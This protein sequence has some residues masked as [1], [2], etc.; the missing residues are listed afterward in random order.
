MIKQTLI[1]FSLLSA[2][3]LSQ[4]QAEY[5]KDSNI[6]L[7]QESEQKRHKKPVFTDIDLDENGSI[8]LEEFKQHEI[9]RGEHKDV[10][11]HIDYNGDGSISKEELANHKPPRHPRKKR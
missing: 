2:F 9:P 5:S 11:S 3:S 6:K 8:T 10:F 7:D 1:A 4:V